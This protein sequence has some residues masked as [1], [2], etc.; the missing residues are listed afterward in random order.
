[1]GGGRQLLG[2]KMGYSIPQREIHFWWSNQ[3]LPVDGYGLNSPLMA[4]IHADKRDETEMR[5]MK[6]IH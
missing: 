6:K 3:L 1:M 4:R 2:Q 5:A